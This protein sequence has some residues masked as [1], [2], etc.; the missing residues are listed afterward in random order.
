MVDNKKKAK[1]RSKCKWAENVKVQKLAGIVLFPRFWWLLPMYLVIS[2]SLLLVGAIVLGMA[3]NINTYRLRYDDQCS[4]ITSCTV[5]FTPDVTLESPNIYYEIDNFYGNH[6]NYV[7]SISYSQLRGNTDSSIK[8][9]DPITQNS[10]ISSTLTSLD[11]TVLSQTADVN[12]CG[13]RAKY[14]F[15]DTYVLSQSGTPIDIDDTKISHS[16]DR[17]SKFERPDNYRSIQWK[18]VED[19]HFMVWFQPDT[20]PNFIKLWGR[21]DSDLKKDTTYTLT[22]TNTWATSSIEAKKYVYFSEVNA[23]GGDS[24]VFGLLYVISGSIFF[25]LAIVMVWLEIFKKKGRSNHN[26][27]MSNQQILS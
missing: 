18:D 14:Y 23:F 24:M 3:N 12:P 22:I 1:T 21:I 11:G 20:F 13:L 4:G 19:E 10:D 2:F 15:T 25:L 5:N 27:V 7:K 26:R 16:V 6:R 17:N 9:W 8:D